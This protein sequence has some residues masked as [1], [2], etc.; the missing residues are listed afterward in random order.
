MNN[1]KIIKKNKFSI[2]DE[3]VFTNINK[4]ASIRENF[5]LLMNNVPVNT[6]NEV[7]LQSSLLSK[8]TKTTNQLTRKAATNSL[9]KCF[10]LAN[11]LKSIRRRLSIEDIQLVS[12]Y[13][14]ECSANAV[15]GVNRVLQNRIIDILDFD[16]TRTK[17]TFHEYE[18]INLEDQN[19]FY[20]KQTLNELIEKQ[21]KIISLITE[22][23]DIHLNINQSIQIKTNSIDFCLKKLH[24]TI[25][26]RTIIE[27]LAIADDGE[28]SYTNLSRSLSSS[29]LLDE[30]R[31]EFFIPRDPNLSFP[32]LIIQHVTSF[33]NRKRSLFYYHLFNLTRDNRNLTF[34]SHFELY[35]MNL[36]ISYLFVYAFDQQNMKNW[37]VFCSDR[38]LNENEYYQH[39]LNNEQ[40]AEHHSIV[41]G[42]REMNRNE[43]QEYC[44]NRTTTELKV[45]EP[46]VFTSNYRIRIYQSACFYLDS[47]N[48]WQTD[49]LIVSFER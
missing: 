19:L 39:F 41:Y 15:E 22:T 9:N 49:G 33:A 21:K 18:D 26:N 1:E 34:S 43:F 35:P 42:I 17:E 16:L 44:L 45:N 24:R 37:S 12:A 40:T 46:V 25:L 4:H 32:S 11:Q 31:R 20:Q 5:T 13:L 3:T 36:N 8:L 28:R 14:L 27:R 7:K 10:Q 48:Q 29:L 47:N 2:I 23:I 38:D 30:N 6:I